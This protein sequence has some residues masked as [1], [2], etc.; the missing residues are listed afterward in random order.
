MFT[1][2]RELGFS[3]IPVYKSAK[4]P[5][6]NEWSQFCDRLPTAKEAELWDKEYDGFNIG[7]A[8]GSASNLM[9]VDIDTDDQ[10]I[11]DACPPSPV[12]KRGVKGET[13]FFKYNAAIASHKIGGKIDILCGGRQT[14]I[15]PSIHPKTG[16]SY[17]W[18]T[19]DHLGDAE[20][21]E[22]TL[23]DIAF[24]ASLFKESITTQEGG[25]NDHLKSIVTSMRA[26]HCDEKEIVQEIYNYDLENHN[27]R[28]F[29]GS[30]EDFK[31]SN[32]S[33]AMRNAWLFTIRN[34]LSLVRKNVVEFMPIERVQ[35][36]PKHVSYEFKEYPKPRGVMADFVKLCDATSKGRQ[37]ALGLGG[38]LAMVAALA[39][40]RV[41]SRVRD[42]D[43]WPN[44]FILNLGFS[45]FGKETPQRYIDEF[46]IDTN[47]IGSANYRSG[48]SIV[49]SLP[50]QQERIDLI[51]ECSALLK[52]MNGR[53]A[54]QSE[55]VEILSLLFSKSSSRFGGFSSLSMGE[56][57]GAA[58]NPCVN[59]LG[60]TTPAGFRSSVSKDMS[61]KGLMPRFIAFFQKEVGEYK[62]RKPRAKTIES[63][64]ARI[65]AFVTWAEGQDKPVHPSFRPEK[66]IMA[67]RKN[68]NDEDVTQGIRYLPELI[69]FSEDAHNAFL[70]YEEKYHIQS[71]K[72]PDEFESAFLTRFAELA[73]KIALLDAF[74]LQRDTIELDSFEWAVGV[75]E[76]Q[77]HNI[78][79][80]YEIAAAENYQESSLLR[81]LKLIESS[82]HIGKNELSRKT[83][84]LNSRQRKEILDMLIESGQIKSQDLTEKGNS[85]KSKTILVA[86][87]AEK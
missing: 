31:A 6:L 43:V 77:W 70:D 68:D 50:K 76:T 54:F 33:Q 87:Y 52:T 17:E 14:V 84:W 63:Y 26:R 29:F 55:I 42:H 19:P 48:S 66:N 61:A 75:V 3:A 60:S 46:L 4:N 65:E 72:M 86:C 82:G 53:E 20:L 5:V 58:Y 69:P 40:N 78:K 9:A 45:G 83:Q 62:G 7:I 10:T 21:P 28:L 22:I 13:R 32:E 16:K 34:T 30:N 64:R 49:M 39:S 38:A 47:L 44:L 18:V 67:K 12:R 8:L 25:R 11:L 35:E 1:R 24:I 71:S 79:P 41:R 57:F 73:A 23:E 2:Y 81:V 74:S 36:L 51:D 85:G 56:K 80:M 15:P 37:D 27:P 59:I